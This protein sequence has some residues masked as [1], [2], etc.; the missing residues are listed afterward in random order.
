MPT[1]TEEEARQLKAELL[2]LAKVGAPKPKVGTRLG[3]ALI[4]F[5]TPPK[6]R[7]VGLTRAAVPIPRSHGAG[8]GIPP[9]FPVKRRST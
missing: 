5:T 4:A 3:D 2:A 6:Y 1:Y 9:R 7:G 8:L